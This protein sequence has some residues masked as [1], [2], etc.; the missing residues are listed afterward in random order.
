M[1]TALEIRAQAQARLRAG[2]AAEGT[3]LLA[4]L[5]RRQP[6][7]EV[8]NDWA[9]GRE[10]LG[11]ASDA[12]NGYLQALRMDVF[13]PQ[14]LG[15]LG[16]LWARQGHWRQ[17]APV[18]ER[19][20]ALQ[21]G[22]GAPAGLRGL[23]REAREREQRE[24]AGRP[25]LR[26]LFVHEHV[27]EADHNGADQRVMTLLA[28]LRQLGHAVT[29]LSRTGPGQ[30]SYLPALAGVCAAVHY[31]D[32][33]RLRWRVEESP[34]WQLDG[35]LAG[36]HFDAAVICHWNWLG[37][38]CTEQYLSPIRRHSPRTR[39]IVLSE[40]HH[41]LL[42]EQRAAITGH[43]MDRERARNFSHRELDVYARADL[44][45]T[46]SSA[47]RAGILARDP[48]LRIEVL[49]PVIPIAPSGPGFA[50]RSGLLFLGAF[51]NPANTDGLDWFFAAAW[52]EIR[53]RLPGVRLHL[54]GSDLPARYR[55]LPG[56][57]A[58]GY[59][60]DLDV[61]FARHRLAIS[62]IRFG[63]GAKTKAMA[64]LARGL[65]FVA[66]PRGVDGLEVRDGEQALIADDAAGFA[67]AVVR[68]YQDPALWERLAAGG[69][70]HAAQNFSSARLAGRI[71]E[72]LAAVLAA[73]PQPARPIGPVS[74]LWVEEHFFDLLTFQPARDRVSYR[75]RRYLD[76]AEAELAA[77]RRDAARAQCGHTLPFV[78]PAD[79][80]WAGR[81]RDIL[82]RI[83]P[84]APTPPEPAGATA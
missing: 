22:A 19:A 40:D 11:N 79:T 30:E 50:E 54:A 77:G 66:T 31:M 58:E 59:A 5:L 13:Q 36:G 71:R 46:V 47:D 29:F 34:A 73:P 52:A 20:V 18:L 44:V 43:W 82:D 70:A 8:W 15:N 35:V 23:A 60:A 53:R 80:A 33:E 72:T 10:M 1:P 9:L 17:A 76:L 28:A 21:G 51:L 27:P 7:A 3:A 57:V 84:A 56:V 55:D 62:P 41:G 26:I 65:P 37:I 4:A 68:L 38:A 2:R 63:T 48:S 45:W 81:I 49:P 78:R 83:G 6:A 24:L 75:L 42:E 16:R 74:P 64:A 25:G 14:A 61:V 12:E 67:A 69:R 32:A 39:V